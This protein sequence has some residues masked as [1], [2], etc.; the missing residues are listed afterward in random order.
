LLQVGRD[1]PLTFNRLF[2]AAHRVRSRSTLIGIIPLAS[3]TDKSSKTSIKQDLRLGSLRTFLPLSPSAFL[4][5][6]ARFY[7]LESLFEFSIGRIK[8][9]CDSQQSLSEAQIIRFDRCLSTLPLPSGLDVR[10]CIG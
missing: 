5:A 7:V 2:A 8:G 3:T 9:Y 1:P 6:I 4:G 10:A